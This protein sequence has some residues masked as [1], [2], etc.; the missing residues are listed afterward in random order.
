M[1][2]ASNRHNSKMNH[3]AVDPDAQSRYELRAPVAGDLGWVVSTHAEVYCNEYGWDWRFEGM[4]ADIVARF[5][6]SF[7]AQ[8]ESCWIAID[9][10]TGERLGSV[11][12]VAESAVLAKLRML[13]LTPSA[14]GMGLGAA[15]T[16]TA[17]SFARSKGYTH[18]VLWTNNCLTSARSIYQKRGFELESSEPYEDF[19]QKLTSEVWRV[20][21]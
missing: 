2:V 1:Y 11:F 20:A 7:D 15:L 9:A 17:M 14:R 8:R 21:L 10:Q 16:D 18:M 5:V 19:G 3:T 4:V 13:I 6:E 12:V